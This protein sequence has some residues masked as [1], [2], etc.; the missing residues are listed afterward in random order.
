MQRNPSLN[1]NKCLAEAF[2][3]RTLEAIK[4]VRKRPAYKELLRNL[5]TSTRKQDG[6]SSLPSEGPSVSSEA[7][8][9]SLEELTHDWAADLKKAVVESEINLDGLRLNDI[10]PGVPTDWV[11]EAVDANYEAWLPAPTTWGGTNVPGFL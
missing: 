4:G 3:N 7:H 2:P 9:A 5:T 6:A 10:K 11:R 8:Q 1:V